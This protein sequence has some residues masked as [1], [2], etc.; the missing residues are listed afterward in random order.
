[1]PHLPNGP[2]PS[3]LLAA[4]YQGTSALHLLDDE[5]PSMPLVAA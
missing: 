5:D 3:V 1:V 4:A 2:S